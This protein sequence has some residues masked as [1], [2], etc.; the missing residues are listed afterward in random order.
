MSKRLLIILIVLLSLLVLVN[1]LNIEKRREIAEIQK[2]SNNAPVR[3][4][5][6]LFFTDHTGKKID[7]AYLSRKNVYVQFASP[8]NSEDIALLSY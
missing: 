5:P 6:Q 3:R 8:Q 7:P 1:I 4:L 2:K